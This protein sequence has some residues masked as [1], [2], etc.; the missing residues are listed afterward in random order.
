MVRI[1]TEEFEK[2]VE[3]AF[4][5]LPDNFKKKL[6]NIAIVIEDYPSF[7]GPH[8]RFSILGLYTG[9]P[10]PKRGIYYGNVLPDVIT[11]YQKPIEVQASSID[12]LK[13]LVEKVLF[14]EIGHYFGFSDEELYEIMGR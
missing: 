7:L 14:H 6:E 11:I 10:Y 9:I 3:E 13:S 8:H 12:E 4:E 1:S 2:I 5:R